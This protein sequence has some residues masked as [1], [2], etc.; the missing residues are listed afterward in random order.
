MIFVSDHA[1]SSKW[2]WIGAIRNTRLRVVWKEITWITTDSASIT[3]M[4]PSR[5][6]STSV[7]VITASPAIAPPSPSEPVSPMKIVAGKAL[8]QRKPMH[9]ADQAAGEHRQVE[10]AGE[11]RDP[12]V[13]EQHDRRAARRQ[14]VE[15]VGQVDRAGR[16]RH[17]E[18]DQQ[19]IER[20]EVDVVVDEAQPQRRRAGAPRACAMHHSPS[21]IAIVTTSFV[22]ARRPSERRL[23]SFV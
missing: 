6:S 22:R 15:P 14:A 13:G 19:R 20:P 8:N 18:V 23:T 17:D 12:D 4:P 3:K 5:I 2:W 7:F 1:F 9:A 21:E 11:E 10:V 16:A